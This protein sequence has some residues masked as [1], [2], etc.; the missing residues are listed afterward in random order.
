MPTELA[1]LLQERG[2]RQVVVCGLATDYCVRATALDARQLGLATTVLRRLIRA[3][4]LAPG[5][6]QRAIDEML[7]AGVLMEG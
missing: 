5:D 6:G 4:D 7:A 2:I 3:V 1:G